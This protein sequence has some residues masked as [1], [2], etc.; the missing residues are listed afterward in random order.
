LISDALK[1]SANM[2][3]GIKFEEFLYYPFVMKQR[4]IEELNSW[5]K[6]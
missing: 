5:D 6:K 3:G 4:I 1:V 2:N